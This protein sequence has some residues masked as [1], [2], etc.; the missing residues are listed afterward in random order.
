M[1]LSTATRGK[2]KDAFTSVLDFYSL[3]FFWLMRVVFGCF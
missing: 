3:D 1:I 2:P